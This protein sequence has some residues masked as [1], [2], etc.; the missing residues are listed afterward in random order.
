MIIPSQ[1]TL[2]VRMGWSSVGYPDNLRF[3]QLLAL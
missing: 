3:P 2:I 1:Q